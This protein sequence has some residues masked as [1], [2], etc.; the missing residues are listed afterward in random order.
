MAYP[1]NQRTENPQTKKAEGGILVRYARLGCI[2]LNVE[3][4]LVEERKIR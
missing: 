4:G 3:I 2:Y 1:N